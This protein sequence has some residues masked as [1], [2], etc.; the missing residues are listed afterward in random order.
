MD[1][2]WKPVGEVLGN[3]E[4]CDLPKGCVPLD[5]V[6]VV[7]AL[8][9]EGVAQWYTRSTRTTTNFETLGAL[10]VAHR[11]HLDGVIESYVDI[12]NDEES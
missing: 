11:L 3:M 12:D 6:F 5:G 2:N 1:R 9:G 4:I 7:K 8:D 10:Q